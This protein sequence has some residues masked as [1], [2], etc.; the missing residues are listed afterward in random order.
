[1][2]EEITRK[3]LIDPLLEQRGWKV[4]DKRFVYPEFPIVGAVDDQ[5]NPVNDRFVDYVLF[6]NVGDP[7]AIVEAK[8][9]QRNPNEGK[10]QAREYFEYI[11]QKYN[12]ECF[13]FLTNGEDILF[14]DY[15]NSSTRKVMGFFTQDELMQRRKQIQSSSDPTTI[16]INESITERPYQL[17]AIKRVMEGIAK[18]KR[19]FLYWGLS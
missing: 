17:E 3:K 10:E 8:K 2:K 18:N 19:K 13:I 4:H 9:W 5:G 14:W 16:K 12:K 6:D 15:P 7:L 11:K 1:M